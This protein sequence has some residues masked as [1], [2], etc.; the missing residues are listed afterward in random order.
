VEFCEYISG[1]INNIG[2][3]SQRVYRGHGCLLWKL[4]PTLFRHIDGTSTP[5]NIRSDLLL[6]YTSII[7]SY[8]TTLSQIDSNFQRIF[9]DEFSKASCERYHINMFEYHISIAQHHGLFTPGLDWTGSPL[10]AAFMAIQFMPSSS[11]MIR[12]FELDKVSIPRRIKLYEAP[13]KRMAAQRGAISLVYKDDERTEICTDTIDEI[14]DQ[15]ELR[16][17]DIDVSES[18]R[19]SILRFLNSNR[20]SIEEMF[21]E[22]DYWLSQAR[23]A[24]ILRIASGMS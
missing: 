17:F 11:R 5:K 3:N 15:I 2:D 12:I 13:F 14:E 19:A 7:K 1:Q 18:E 22:S 16:H 4:T 8:I 20:I 24:E 9:G 10:V 6:R 23:N 21:P